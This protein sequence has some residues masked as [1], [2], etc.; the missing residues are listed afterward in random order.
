MSA[1]TAHRFAC[2]LAIISTKNAATFTVAFCARLPDTARTARCGRWWCW[3]C[4]RAMTAHIYAVV[5]LQAVKMVG[6]VPRARARRSSMRTLIHVA[7]GTY[8][9]FAFFPAYV[10]DVGALSLRMKEGSE[11]GR[12]CG[13]AVAEQYVMS[14]VWNSTR[15]I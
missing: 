6:D 9:I 14:V 4:T 8:R 1:H 3:A 12:I 13:Y 7:F 15:I 11:P 10:G 2:L 5:Y